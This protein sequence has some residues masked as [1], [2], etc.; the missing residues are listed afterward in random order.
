MLCQIKNEPNQREYPALILCEIK[1]DCVYPLVH[2]V[3]HR[4]SEFVM[5]MNQIKVKYDGLSL[6]GKQ[7][8]VVGGTAGIG[9]GIALRFARTNANV[10][11]I[12][13]NQERGQAVVEEMQSIS[14]DAN[15]AFIPCNAELLS[16]VKKTC[17]DLNV[18][19]VDYLIL[20]QGMATIQGRTETLEGIDQK[21]ALHFYS[22]MQFINQLTHLLIKSANPRVLSV[23]SAGIHS[24]YSKYREDVELKHNYSLKNAADAAGFYTDIALTAFSRQ[25]PHITFIHSAPGF[26]NSN[27][28]TEMPL[29]IRKPLNIIKSLFGR[30]IHEC[31]EYLCDALFDPGLKGGFH[32]RGSDAQVASIHSSQEEAFPIV[33]QHVQDVLQK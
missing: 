3:Y 12:G 11:I 31:A 8:L 23:L 16:N 30:S 22:R 20:S 27:W 2:I 15:F 21:L 19:R 9:K 28:G 5:K 25:Y 18:P 1:I 13:R 7:V 29:W 24:S 26:V 32:L 4:H 14:P 6:Q 10:T 33:W 17:S